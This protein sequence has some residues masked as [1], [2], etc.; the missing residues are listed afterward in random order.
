VIDAAGKV[1]VPSDTISAIN[2]IS[3][4][5]RSDRAGTAKVGRLAAELTSDFHWH[6]T[7]EKRYIGGD[8][9]APTCRPVG[10]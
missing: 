10:F 8:H 6:P 7:Q 1:E 4:T 5:K 2:R 9:R 3:L